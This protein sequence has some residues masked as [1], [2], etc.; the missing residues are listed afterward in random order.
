MNSRVK[1]F[2]FTFLLF[3]TLV[4]LLWRAIDEKFKAEALLAPRFSIKEKDLTH[5]KEQLQKMLMDRPEM[6]MFVA[7]NDPVCS[8]TVRQFAGAGIGK[9]IYWNG[10]EPDSR[11]VSQEMLNLG[12]NEYPLTGSP[13]IR[14]SASAPKGTLRGEMQWATA[15][16]ELFN[17]RNGSA[18]LQLNRDVQLGKIDREQWCD[19]NSKME[20]NAL[21][22]AKRFYQVVWLPNA[23]WKRVGTRPDNWHA[24]QSESY[25]DWLKN[26]GRLYKSFWN[27]VYPKETESCG[28]KN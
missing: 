19:L 28:R 25:S 10:D 26:E 13:C 1:L 12:S 2:A 21:L 23:A 3:L 5:G 18:F 7:E 24:Y 27:S 4:L 6:V 14:V 11:G 15:V 8:W 22:D 17:I 9:R 20:F 16:F